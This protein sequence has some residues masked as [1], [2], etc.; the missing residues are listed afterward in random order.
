MVA[1]SISFADAGVPCCAVAVAASKRVGDA[2]AFGIVAAGVDSGPT[3]V[4]ASTA[5]RESNAADKSSVDAVTTAAGVD[6]GA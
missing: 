6:V 5:L 2:P 1:V 3:F 4:V